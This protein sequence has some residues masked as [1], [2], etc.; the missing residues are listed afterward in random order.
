MLI[1]PVN[2]PEPETFDPTRYLIDGQIKL[3]EAFNPFGFGRHRCMGDLLGRQNLFMF[4]TTLLQNFKLVAIPGQ[5]PEEVPL[6]GATAAVKPYDA[7]LVSRL[8]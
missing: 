1:N 8:T 5:M 4:T 6:E 2:F 3:P 7:M